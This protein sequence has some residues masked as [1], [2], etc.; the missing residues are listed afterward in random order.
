MK[1]ILI[2]SLNH[3]HRHISIQIIPEKLIDRIKAEIKDTTHSSIQKALKAVA[4]HPNRKK[5]ERTF[6]IQLLRSFMQAKYTGDPIG[7][8][9]LGFKDYCHFTSPIRRYP[10]LVVHR[11]LERLVSH[12]NR[13]YKKC[14]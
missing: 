9:G 11:V 13:S 1:S 3:F 4:S 12:K 14:L 8:W 5:I 10:D 6:N 7:H 2:H